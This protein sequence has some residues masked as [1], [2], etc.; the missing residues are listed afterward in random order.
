M[1]E[2]VFPA[3]PET[4]RSGPLESVPSPSRLRRDL[5]ACASINSDVFLAFSLLGKAFKPLPFG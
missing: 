4:I 2:F 5:A 3:S 1:I